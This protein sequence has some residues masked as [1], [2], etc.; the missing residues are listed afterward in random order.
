MAALSGAPQHPAPVAAGAAQQLQVD[1]E[2][3]QGQL[4]LAAH[5]LV[6]VLP[7]SI[8]RLLPLLAV[9][10]LH[11]LVRMLLN[12]CTLTGKEPGQWK[13]LPT[14]SEGLV[15]QMAMQVCMREATGR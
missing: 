12:S 2:G 15:E 9:R 6:H 13:L 8:L 11:L 1:R 5:T 10:I 7:R 14:A 4:A 3:L